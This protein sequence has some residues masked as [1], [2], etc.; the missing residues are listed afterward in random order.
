[1]NEEVFL[2]VV[3]GLPNNLH[4]EAVKMEA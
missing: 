4:F 3:A 1:M 2:I